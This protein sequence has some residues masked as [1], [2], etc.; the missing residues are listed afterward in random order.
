MWW[1]ALA[2]AAPADTIGADDTVSDG[3]VSDEIIVWQR[4]FARFDDKRWLV[5]SEVITPAVTPLGTEKTPIRA[6]AWQLEAVVHCRLEDRSGRLREVACAIEQAALRVHV[7]RAAAGGEEEQAIRD[8]AA[9]LQG[10]VLQLQAHKRGKV[11]YSDIDG[12]DGDA[13]R[14][15]RLITGIHTLTSQVAGAF[16]MDFPKDDDPR[17][18]TWVSYQE[19]L[20]LVASPVRGMGAV[21]VLHRVDVVDGKWVQQTQGRSTSVSP[22]PNPNAGLPCRGPDPRG[23]SSRSPVPAASMDARCTASMLYQ[24]DFLDSTMSYALE[25]AGVSVVDPDAGYPIERVWTVTGRPTAGSAS[26]VDYWSAGELKALGADEV[27]ELGATGLVGP[28]HAAGG[29]LPAWISVARKEGG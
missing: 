25:I 29:E 13:V 6:S 21:E 11:P 20:L 15:R 10:A 12:L 1:L 24:P 9:T 14:S 28:P 7:P 27:V 2:A 19:P 4:P 5:R 18:H 23:S 22:M 26:G 3:T 16:H 8:L 17:G